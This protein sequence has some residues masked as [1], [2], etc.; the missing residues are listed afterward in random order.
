MVMSEPV[1][2]W[3]SPLVG[4]TIKLTPQQFMTGAAIPGVA[5][6]LPKDPAVAAQLKEIDKG[7]VR[8]F[9][10]DGAGD[11]TDEMLGSDDDV[12]ARLIHIVC[13]ELASTM[14]P[15]VRKVEA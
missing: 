7:R 13:M 1:A 3:C 2:S 8:Q 14:N 5:F 11:V 12:C 4:I 9:L 10:R 6:Q 15:Q